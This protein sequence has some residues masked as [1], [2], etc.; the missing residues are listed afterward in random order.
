LNKPVDNS[1]ALLNHA[2]RFAEIRLIGEEGEQLGI[3]SS[4]D[5][6]KQAD[7]AGI[8]LVCISPAATPPVCKLMDYNKFR[9]Q[10]EKKTKEAKKKQVVIDIKEIKL[11]IKIADHDLEYKVKHAEEFLEAKKHVKFR[12]FL[13]GREMANPGA[14]VNMLNRVY[15][16][17][18]EVGERDKEPIFEG[19]FVNMT[20][21]PRKAKK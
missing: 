15:E 8:D 9:Y 16:K 1:Q 20:L 18:A 10:Q 14:G 21:L 12:V 13:S 2:I 4:F 6:Q 7:T 17:L 3:F 11:T 19:R 5:A